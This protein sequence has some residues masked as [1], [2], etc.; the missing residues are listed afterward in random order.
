MV[1]IDGQPNAQSEQENAAN[2]RRSQPRLALLLRSGKLVGPRGEFLCIV[3]DLSE[4]GARLRLF[5]PLVDETDL[6]LE[7]VNRQ[8]FIVE[9][10]WEDADEA[11]FRFVDDIN[12]RGFLSGTGPFPKRPLR[13]HL[14]HLATLKYAGR[15]T[16]A[17]IHD[18]SREGVRIQTSEHLA[19]SQ[20]IR[21]ESEHL[22]IFE[23]T[24]RWR[25]HPFYG[26]SLHHVMTLE[27]L[28]HRVHKVQLV[29]R[30]CNL[31]LRQ[32]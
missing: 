29:N 6:S 26:L 12:L 10:V 17:V 28:A 7:I 27:D 14:H 5:H 31:G 3:R 23:A 20:N 22:P 2:D 11:G 1:A 8:R 32:R 19:I 21:I 13:I 15:V 25:R 16:A 24:V 18:L 9:K 30:R 4:S